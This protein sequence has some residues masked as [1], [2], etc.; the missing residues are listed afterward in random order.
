MRVKFK[1]SGLVGTVAEQYTN[2]ARV[3][4]DNG[5]YW[6]VKDDEIEYL[7]A[8]ASSYS[9]ILDRLEVPLICKP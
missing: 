1:A 8:N 2:G 5:T 7:Q 3:R 4:W 6:T 9:E